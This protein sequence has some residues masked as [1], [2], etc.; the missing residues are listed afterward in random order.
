MRTIEQLRWWIALVREE[1]ER[2]HVGAWSSD[3]ASGLRLHVPEHRHMQ[4]AHDLAASGVPMLASGGTSTFE[5]DD[6]G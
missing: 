2:M 5:F 1:Y 3:E 4:G 6:V